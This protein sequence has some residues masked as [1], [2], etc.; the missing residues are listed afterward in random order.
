MGGDIQ[1]RGRAV[2]LTGVI[3]GTE[4]TSRGLEIRTVSLGNITLNSNINLQGGELDLRTDRIG[5]R[6]ITTGSPVIMVGVLSLLEGANTET[7]DT[8]Y[9]ANLFSTMSRATD[10]AIIR[11]AANATAA[12]IHPW[13][14]GLNSASFI[15]QAVGGLIPM[16][17]LP[18]LFESTGDIILRADA[19]ALSGDAT[20]ILSGAAVNLA[21]GIT[22]AGG[23]NLTASDRLT[24]NSGIAIG[25]A[26]AIIA[27]ER[28]NLATPNTVITA[29][30]TFTINFTDPDVAGDEDAGFSLDS[31]TT[32]TRNNFAA[33][34]STP[35]ITFIPDIP[36]D[37]CIRNN[38]ACLA[39]YSRYR[40]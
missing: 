36:D 40:R 8:G 27:G 24:L 2:E 16:V 14:A 33:S 31:G 15:L 37:D 4:G 10:Q 30:G 23:L 21:G 12:V 28:I 38:E 17:T 34:S 19:I 20:T 39:R 11:V 3:A 6:I 32:T 9:T 25:G 5:G 35:T 26:L 13:M 29:G 1:L 22:G 7:T 18:A